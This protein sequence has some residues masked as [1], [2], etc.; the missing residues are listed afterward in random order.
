VQP[1]KFDLAVNLKTA[2]QIAVTIPPPVLARA[3]KVIK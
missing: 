3:N 2:N 1:T